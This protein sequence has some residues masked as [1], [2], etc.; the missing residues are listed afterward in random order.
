MYVVADYEIKD[1]M[2]IFLVWNILMHTKAT[3]SSKK[4]TPVYTRKKINFSPVVHSSE[5][6]QNWQP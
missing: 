5:W 1:L 6:W 3:D 4:T 2:I